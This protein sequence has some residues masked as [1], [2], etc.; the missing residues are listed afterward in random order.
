MVARNKIPILDP[1]EDSPSYLNSL[2]SGFTFECLAAVFSLALDETTDAHRSSLSGLRRV[3][4]CTTN[5]IVPLGAEYVNV[6]VCSGAPLHASHTLWR[7]YHWLRVTH[8]D[9][10]EGSVLYSTSR[11][12]FII[13]GASQE[14]YP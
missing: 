8:A 10:I 9:R 12:K 6:V 5:S 4:F 11:S 13:L 1:F 14:Y 7:D 3:F 2:Q